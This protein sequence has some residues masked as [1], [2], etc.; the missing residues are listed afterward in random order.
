MIF[1]TLL[2]PDATTRMS[3]RPNL[4][5]AAFTILWQFSSELGRSA[6]ISALAPSFSHSAATFLSSSALLAASTT[7]APAPASVFAASAPKA[8]DAPVMMAVLPLMSNS[9]RGLF[10]N[11]SD[12]VPSQACRPSLGWIGYRHHDRAHLVAAVDDFTRFILFDHA[13]IV[14][15]QN[16]FLAVDDDGQFTAQHEIDLLRR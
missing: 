15:F 14:G 12:M 7:L 8:P 5:T 9:A 10:R 16:R 3:T 13:G 2:R 4:S 6:M 11:A 1:D